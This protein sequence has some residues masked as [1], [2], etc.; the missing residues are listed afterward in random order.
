MQSNSIKVNMLFLL[1]TMFFLS[2][3][4]TGCFE[5]SYSPFEKGATREREAEKK[6]EEAKDNMALI[7]K[8]FGINEEDVSDR[9]LGKRIY[10]TIIHFDEEKN[11]QVTLEELTNLVVAKIERGYEV[12]KFVDG[13][14]PA[15]TINLAEPTDKAVNILSIL[16]FTGSVFDIPVVGDL[17]PGFSTIIGWGARTA[18]RALELTGMLT[19]VAYRDSLRAYIDDRNRNKF[20]SS[21]EAIDI[22]TIA[23]LSPTGLSDQL[24]KQYQMGMG[25]DSLNL[26]ATQR[27]AGLRNLIQ[28]IGTYSAGGC[29][30][31][32]R[33]FE[34]DY[35]S[36]ILA[37]D[38]KYREEIKN[39]ILGSN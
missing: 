17:P 25:F 19:E 31:L 13:N 34:F 16:D 11:K 30:D 24:D 38:D 8:H 27:S 15:E 23:V 7:R 3:T 32:M 9:D 22:A 5:T 26:V 33:V 35:Q 12:E 6:A 20:D 1:I 2:L 36:Y 10:G 28:G 14:K 29:K 39:V 37:T 21:E 18:A 4:F